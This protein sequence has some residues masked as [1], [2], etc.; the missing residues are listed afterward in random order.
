M[1]PSLITPGLCSSHGFRNG[2]GRSCPLSSFPRAAGCWRQLPGGARGPI[3]VPNVQ[4]GDEAVVGSSAMR[5][6]VLLQDLGL[7]V[8]RPLYRA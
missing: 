6:H 8:C 5:C 1:P 2:V 3:S 7:L 4:Q